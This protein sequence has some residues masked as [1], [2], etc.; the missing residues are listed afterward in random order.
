VNDHRSDPGA[1]ALGDFV[2]DAEVVGTRLDVAVAGALAISRSRAAARIAD[3]DVTVDGRAVNKQHR[4]RAGERV[5]MSEPAPPVAAGPAPPVPPVRFEDEHLLVV[6]KPAGLVVHP[7]AGTRDGTL[8]DALLATGGPLAPA[9]GEGR[10]GIVHRLDR[11]TSGLLMI[12]RTDE[13]HAGL[14]AA[15]R[16]RRVTRHYLA[17]VA[18]V[19]RAAR[20]RIEG[21]IGRDPTDRLRFAVVA[22]GKPAVTR[23][24][25]LATGSVPDL[26]AH[27]AEV[28]LLACRLESGRTH[29]IRVH[30]TTLGHPVVG[31]PTYG[32]RTELAR[33]LGLTRPF[34]HAAAL[35]FDHPVTGDRIDLVEPLPQALA[36]ALALAAIE[37]PGA[38]RLGEG[39]LVTGS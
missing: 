12:A 37:A 8:V 35:A 3:G 33:A 7:G 36:D 4:L 16:E 19:P 30:L 26:A 17:L 34:L 9:G 24:R 31:D 39:D 10:P 20:G 1:Q 18:G 14:V 27:R 13:A 28:S 6:A 11:D 38:E 22:D 25:T 23:Y 15:L 32:R 21:P 2:V 29:Q 5:V